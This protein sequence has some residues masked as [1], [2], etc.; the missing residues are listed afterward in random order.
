MAPLALVGAAV[1]AEPG[2][3]RAV[4]LAVADEEVGAE[5]EQVVV[6]AG[7]AVDE[8]DPP[9]HAAPLGASSPKLETKERI[10][11]SP[12]LRFPGMARILP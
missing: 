3:L 10:P 11:I 1:A 2:L 12:Q 4:A 9:T 6:E 5:A 8:A 7:E